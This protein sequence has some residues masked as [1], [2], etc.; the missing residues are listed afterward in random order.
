MPPPAASGAWP[1]AA[2]AFGE[3]AIAKLAEV[4]LC[5]LRRS[6]GARLGRLSVRRLWSTARRHAAVHRGRVHDEVVFARSKSSQSV[7]I[8]PM[9]LTSPPPSMSP[10]I[11]AMCCTRHGAR[12]ETCH[13]CLGQHRL[14]PGT[15]CGRRRLSAISSTTRVR[16][17]RPGRPPCVLPPPLPGWPATRP[18]RRDHA[19]NLR[20][21]VRPGQHH[22]QVVRQQRRAARGRPRA[23]SARRRFSVPQQLDQLA[24]FALFVRSD[25]FAQL[26]QVGVGILRLQ[27]VGA[28]RGGNP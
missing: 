28:A 2:G 25:F 18:P 4:V 7:N 22:L 1:A 14:I 5:A 19:P 17:L 24:E 9:R 8:T 27:L 15:T 10:A 16:H 20:T 3:R 26:A 11:T 21:R 23:R 12:R 13:R 6:L